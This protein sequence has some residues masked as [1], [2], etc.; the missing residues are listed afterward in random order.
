M[1]GVLQ[2]YLF[3]SGLLNRWKN[4]TAE[5]WVNLQLITWPERHQISEKFLEI[6]NYIYGAKTLSWRRLFTAVLFST[7]FIIGFYWLFVRIGTI[8][9]HLPDERILFNNPYF[10]YFG[11][12]ESIHRLHPLSF[13]FVAFDS[14]G[15]NLIPDFI[16]LAETAWILRL[17]SK[18][19]AYLLPLIILD[20]F[21][22]TIICMVAIILS[23]LYTKDF[24]YSGVEITI[25]DAIMFN[26]FGSGN[27][28]F[29]WAVVG[30][31]YTTSIIWVM[32]L[33]TILIVSILKRTSNTLVKILESNFVTQLPVV[34]V[35]GIPCLLSWPILF[36]LRQIA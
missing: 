21:F 16:S 29:L 23:F 6:F 33:L 14:L 20:L 28:P 25:F 17:A 26:F 8:F 7:F 19:G 3:F 13:F 35:V 12:N 11:Y 31:T 24:F 27:T 10:S 34:L 30:T 5:W 2:S 22:T 18:K 4:A 32:F 1:V 15:M 36:V 9:F